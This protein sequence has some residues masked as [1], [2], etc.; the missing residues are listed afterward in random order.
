MNPFT[1]FERLGDIAEI[2]YKTI[3][4]GGGIEFE[5]CVLRF[6][7]IFEDLADAGMIENITKKKI[8]EFLTRDVSLSNMQVIS[9]HTNEVVLVNTEIHELDSF[10][11]RQF[12]AWITGEL[13]KDPIMKKRLCGR[14][15]YEGVK[16][17]LNSYADKE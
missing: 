11:L 6:I 13:C 10:D 16:I 7:R 15:N 8:E 3:Y 17:I 5:K 4:T 1:T 9:R 2:T 14:N 12:I